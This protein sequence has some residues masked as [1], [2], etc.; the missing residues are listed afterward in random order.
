MS[1]R[2]WVAEG[3]ASDGDV[4][5]RAL[6]VPGAGAPPPGFAPAG[7]GGDVQRARASILKTHLG[8]IPSCPCIAAMLPQN[9]TADGQPLSAQETVDA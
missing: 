6:Q 1:R 5:G 3:F 7:L 9:G 2:I 8:D 4:Y